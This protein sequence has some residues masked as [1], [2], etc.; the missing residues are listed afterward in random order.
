MALNAGEGTLGG[1]EE[2]AVARGGAEGD[3]P[4]V[5]NA[6][7]NSRATSVAGSA[8]IVFGPPRAQMHC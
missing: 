7:S 1:R 5:R 4:V 3:A 8:S 6:T 2:G